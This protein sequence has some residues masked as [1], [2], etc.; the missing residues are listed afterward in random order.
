MCVCWL[1]IIER[2]P[3]TCARAVQPWAAIIIGASSGVLYVF[4]SKLMSNVL[5]IDDPLD[6]VA[7]HG[8]CGVWG[9]LVCGIFSHT[10]NYNLAYGEDLALLHGEDRVKGWIYGG[11]GRLFGAQIVYILAITGWVLG[12]MVPFFFIARMLGLLRVD[13]A[14]ERAGLD[15]SHHGGGAYEA[16]NAELAVTTAHKEGKTAGVSKE[17]DA[18]LSRC[19]APAWLPAS[20]A[21]ACLLGCLCALPARL[22]ACARS[23]ADLCAAVLV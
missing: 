4:A 11:D 14:E 7:V 19:A 15:V 3:L 6:A 17:N 18:L 23:L 16:S 9:V 8:F 20:G 21:S 12:H 10:P 5:K 1:P 22:L 13:E 2:Q